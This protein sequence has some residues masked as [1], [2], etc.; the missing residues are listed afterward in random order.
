MG[1]D[2][3]LKDKGTLSAAKLL[4]AVL[5]VIA[6]SCDVIGF[7]GLGGLFTAHVTGNLVILAAHILGEDATVDSTRP[8]IPRCADGSRCGFAAGNALW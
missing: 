2:F 6:G 7:L 1:C 8:T 4:P 5:S 3:L